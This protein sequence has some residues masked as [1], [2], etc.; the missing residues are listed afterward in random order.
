MRWVIGL[1]LTWFVIVN[2]ANLREYLR[3]PRI[4]RGGILACGLGLA[5]SVIGLAGLL[6]RW[7]I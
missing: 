1:T 5:G 4:Y 6:F 7:G 2:L 3:Y